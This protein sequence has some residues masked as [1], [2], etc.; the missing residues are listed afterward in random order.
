MQHLSRR[1]LKGEGSC[2]CANRER[3]LVIMGSLSGSDEGEII[4]SEA[5]KATTSQPSKNDTSVDRHARHRV[6][7]SRSPDEN[8][9]SRPYRDPPPTRRRDSPRGEK[10]SHDGD[11]DD[12]D[13]EYGERRRR[14]PPD[15]RDA[16]RHDPRAD[17]RFH[18]DRRR[19]RVSYA[20]LD[21]GDSADPY[22]RYYDGAADDRY[23]A[24][25]PRTRSRSPARYGRADQRRVRWGA[26]HGP[27]RRDSRARRD[28]R[29][30][31]DQLQ[32]DRK[33]H[34]ESGEGDRRNRDALTARSG[35][36]ADARS[37][38]PPHQTDKPGLHTQRYVQVHYL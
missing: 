34:R 28:S 27:D 37:R 5:E 26:E 18:D 35:H 17:G 7:A 23:R 19:S 33:R 10:R 11:D 22:L 21:Y 24:K 29:D 15:P 25:R 12:D 4:E 8:G 6:P 20:D 31:R 1:S 3:A 16:R 9:P 13:D 36:A 38:E 32:D 14:P 2:V 30:S